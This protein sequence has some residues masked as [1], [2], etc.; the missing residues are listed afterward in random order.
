MILHRLHIDFVAD[1][2][3]QDQLRE[4]LVAAILAGVFPAEEPLPSCRKLALQLRISR[5][6]VALVYESLL[7]DNYL[8]S[9]PRSGYYL[10]PAWQQP[11]NC[12]PERQTEQ[13]GHQAPE[14]SKRFKLCPSNYLASLKPAR[15]MNYPYPFI[16]GQPDTTRFPMEQ[17]R[18]VTR[19]VNSYQH[20]QN[21]LRDQIDQDVPELIEQIRQR[22][23]PKRG[24]IARS[25]EIL[26]TL[27]SQ[28]ALYMLARLL[29]N[30][31]TRVGV[32]NP[33]FREAI[34]AFSL[35]GS[36]IVPHELDDEGVRL[37][38]QSVDCDYYYVT[39]SHQVPTGI[40][41][42]TARRGE[43]LA[44]ARAHDQIIIEDDYDSETNFDPYPQAALKASDADGRVIY[45]SSLSKALSPGLRLGYLVA[46]A[47]LIDELRPLRRLM[48]RHPPTTI[49]YQMAQFLALGYYESYL[50]RYREDSAMRW[51]SVNRALNR[52]L[53]E[54]Q[55]SPG[56]NHANAFWVRMPEHIDT[57]HLAWRAAYAGV[58]IEPGHSHFLG[59][60]IP[61]NYFRLGFH[62]IRP[63][64]IETGIALL[65]QA[66]HGR[67]TLSE[68]HPPLPVAGIN[69]GVNHALPQ[70]RI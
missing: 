56:S 4:G 44:F 3:L 48:Y 1:K 34:N 41:M 21:W 10:H 16:Y 28:N 49:A 31:H 38:E 36:T 8:I 7:E 12:A 40:S 9:R 18:E 47:E 61:A 13:N 37:G 46:P 23:L 24:I 55:R 62:A 59:N 57:E 32:E 69:S 29:F 70:A 39:P 14:W 33:M 19:K 66:A 43:L 25:E 20:D 22:V 67:T 54:A 45:V 50:K 58:L 30:Q 15:W 68:Q 53:P 26:I 35:Q 52:W 65:A 60:T 6:T 11:Q 2:S 17:W 63:N 5:N 42:S 27:G 64:Q 51:A